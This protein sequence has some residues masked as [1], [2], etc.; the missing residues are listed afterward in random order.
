MLKLEKVSHLVVNN[1]R[2]LI[3][4][5]VQIKNL[6]SKILSEVVKILPLEWQRRYG[7]KPLFLETFVQRS[8][9]SG[10]VY[11][12]A[13]WRYLGSTQGKGRQGLRFFFHGKVRDY[14]IYPL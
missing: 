9:F 12:A 10:T 5:W 7:Y 3:L 8:K 11:K 6:G 1:S 14:Y 4:P 13:N 2:F